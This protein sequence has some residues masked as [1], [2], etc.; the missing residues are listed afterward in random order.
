MR[1]ILKRI[2][3]YMI[4][5]I[6]VSTLATLITDTPLNPNYEKIEKIN[7]EYQEIYTYYSDAISNLDELFTTENKLEDK[8]NSFG[9]MYPEYKEEVDKSYE[10]E[11]FDKDEKSKIYELVTDD[12]D[13]KYRV[14]FYD[15]RRL[16]LFQDIFSVILIILYFVGFAYIMNGETLGKRIMKIRIVSNNDKKLTVINY[17]LRTLLVNGLI[18]TFIDLLLLYTLKETVYMNAYNYIYMFSYTLELIIIFTTYINRDNRGIHDLIAN[19]KVLNLNMKE[20]K[21]LKENS[22]NRDV[23]EIK[24]I[25]VIEEKQDSKIEKKMKNRK[26]NR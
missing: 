25:D 4:D 24:E 7:T 10:D 17:L 14:F 12:F 9:D 13:A 22:D 20:N 6:L 19:T 15:M 3:A 5:I 2:G 1:N 26:R 21:S 16:S 18:V 11:K 23:R 8:V